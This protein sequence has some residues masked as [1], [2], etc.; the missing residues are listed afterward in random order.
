MRTP[1]SCALLASDLIA[2]AD[3]DDATKEQAA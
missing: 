1:L 3:T 2:S